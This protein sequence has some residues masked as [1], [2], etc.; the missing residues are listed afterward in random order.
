MGSIDLAELT[1]ERRVLF[2]RHV[3]LALN[4]VQEEGPVGWQ[5]PSF[6]PA[7]LKLFR[8]LEGLCNSEFGAAG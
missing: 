7:W 6:F 2:R 5:D 4:R 3:V 1:N 8:R